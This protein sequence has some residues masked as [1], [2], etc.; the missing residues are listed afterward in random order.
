VIRPAF[1]LAQFIVRDGEDEALI[2]ERAAMLRALRRALRRAF[3]AARAAWLTNQDDDSW[4]D[5]ILYSSR[6]DALRL[7][8]KAH[9]RDGD[10]IAAARRRLPMV[11]VEAGT[12]LIGEH[13]PVTL[14]D[15][16]EGR[17]QQLIA[18]YFMWYP[19][20]RA[21]DQCEGCTLYNGQVRELSYL[22][23]R[24][25]NYATFCQGPYEESLRYRAFMGWEMPWYSVQDS[26]EALLVGRRVN[27]FYL[28][29]YLRDADRVF[30]T[31]WTAGRGVEVMAPGYGLLLDL[32]VYG[33]QEPWQDSPVDWPQPWGGSNG[34]P[35]RSSGRPI[36][37][38]SRL[39]AGRSDDLG[40]G[41]G[42]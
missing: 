26:A 18:Y 38:W 6:E 36:A 10:A 7:R 24:D 42:R 14:L 15:T 4:L 40:I 16:F 5:L 19:G 12:P 37:Q 3:P 20:Q 28:V 34:N 41:G 9:T 25:V 2:A 23:S 31:Y 33:R 27:S 8:E 35:Y 32:T 22:H 30:E 21:E 17:R 39:E 29:C 1:E 11:E 13:G